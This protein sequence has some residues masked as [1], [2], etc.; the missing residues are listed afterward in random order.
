MCLQLVRRDYLMS[1]L[2]ENRNHLSVQAVMSALRWNACEQSKG[3]LV[4]CAIDGNVQSQRNT[5]IVGKGKTRLTQK[6]LRILAALSL[7]LSRVVGQKASLPILF[8]I[9]LT[10]APSLSAQPQTLSKPFLLPVLVLS[11]EGRKLETRCI[12]SVHLR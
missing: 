6:V 7:S 11:Q 2:L 10:G 5:R 1:D 4:Y 12:V 8:V 3:N 9:L